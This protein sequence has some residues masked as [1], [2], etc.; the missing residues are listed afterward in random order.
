MHAVLAAME[1]QDRRLTAA[2][3]EYEAAV[4]IDDEPYLWYRIGTLSLRLG[5]VE[6]AATA[7]ARSVEHDDAP[8]SWLRQAAAVQGLAGRTRDALKI[9]LRILNAHPSDHHA[10][11]SAAKI[12][13]EM[14][15]PD[16][17]AAVLASMDPPWPG[18]RAPA[19]ER[20]R[21]LLAAGRADLAVGLGESASVELG[22]EG[23]LL[24]AAALATEGRVDEA[25]AAYRSAALEECREGVSEESFEA[26]LRL[27]R[28]EAAVDV[29]AAAAR[30]DGT[31][32]AWVTRSAF[33]LLAAD[34]LQEAEGLLDE[35]VCAQPRDVV[36]LELL[37]VVSHGLGRH[38]RAESLLRRGMAL[39]SEAVSLRRRLAALYHDTDREADAA[40]V[41]IEG[42]ATRSD[43]AAVAAAQA[44]LTGAGYPERAIRLAGQFAFASTDMAFQTAAAWERLACIRR[45]KAVFEDLMMHGSR[46]AQVCNYLG[47]MLAERGFELARAETLVRCALEIE[48]DNPFYL[49]SMGWVYYRQGRLDE[50]IAPLRRAH[51]LDPEEAEVM[52]HLGIALCA[53]GSCEEGRALLRAAA[54]RR[55]W[56][57]ELRRMAEGGVP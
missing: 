13:L 38:G 48:P 32:G 25:A 22:G 35:R 5:N 30:C 3:R 51:A 40:R 39:S 17:A 10:A 37:A 29:A 28:P 36:A 24:Y 23:R 44:A 46:S 14:Q 41:L 31:A 47:Y 54:T 56:D 49:D 4:Q 16:S 42:L 1:E 18:E 33:A 21:L 50:A 19:I 2:L 11:L 27:G 57:L 34:R 12:L 6:R 45:S 55:P 7:L 43:T 15:M 20:A 53:T 52:K 9:H 26:L 8:P